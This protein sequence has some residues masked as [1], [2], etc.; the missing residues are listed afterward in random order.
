[1]ENVLVSNTAVASSLSGLIDPVWV[2]FI[3]ETLFERV[4]SNVVPGD[5][6]VCLDQLHEKAAYVINQNAKFFE[7]EYDPLG[8][9]RTEIEG[10]TLFVFVVFFVLIFLLL[11]L[12]IKKLFSF[13]GKVL[14][15]YSKEKT[16]KPFFIA[17]VWG[18]IQTK[19]Y[20]DPTRYLCQMPV[21]VFVN[22]PKLSMPCKHPT[23]Q[24][25]KFWE[26]SSDHR[27]S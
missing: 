12:I 11:S 4:C 1:M 20:G 8:L 24:K 25:W 14:L 17:Q 6:C 5:A 2:D 27:R 9:N 19:S 3:W 7:L 16:S 18:P 26:A 15:A 13:L 10:E 23:Y 21:N 22:T